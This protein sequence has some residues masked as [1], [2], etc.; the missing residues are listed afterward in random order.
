MTGMAERFAIFRGV[1]AALLAG[2]FTL[3]AQAQQVGA[4]ATLPKFDV[5]EYAVE[6]NTRLP[7][8]DIERAVTPFLGVGKTLRDVEA[9]RLALERAYHDAGYLTVLVSIPEQDVGSGEVSL[10]VTE[11]QVERLR[12]KGA[13]YHRPSAIREQLPELAEGNVPYFPEMQ[14]QLDALNRSADLKATPVLKAGRTV[15]TVDIQMEV[16]DTL[17]LHG[18]IDFDNR[19]SANTTAQRLSGTLRYDNLWQRGHSASL[20]LQTSPEKTDEVR[21]A[22]T[23]YVMPVGDRGAAL[24]G[25]AVISRSKFAT[26]A[27]S[28][29][30]GL[31][32]DSNIYGLR[33]ALPLP[34]TA[35]LSQSLSVGLDY[36]DVKQTVV[37][38][39]SSELPAPISYAP[40][41]A[42]WNGS[43]LGEGRSTT[44][45][46]T[47]THGLRG[48]IG[49][50]DAE[51]A[52]KR[53]GASASFFA[54]RSGLQ[55]TETVA[56]W[57]LA[58]KLEMQLAS[59]PLVSNEQFAAG[60]AESVRGYLEGERV[61]DAALRWSFEVRTP[62]V[63]FAGKDS[64]LRLNGLAFYEGAR[65]RTLQSVAPQPP[66][67]LLRGAGLGLRLGGSHGVSL[68]VDWARAIDNADQTRAGDNRV[69]ARLLWDF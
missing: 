40:L 29:G 59:G 51:F 36:K 7:D 66:F 6:G 56:R 58:G 10:T 25:Y 11:G 63:G 20:T 46:A 12:V 42:A 27:G 14:R 16:D 8:I 32:G 34:G 2:V 60:G 41:V 26:L 45:D 5:M 62:K 50:R 57:T 47:A 17:P 15:G 53:S 4:E 30:L 23:T 52:A 68:D 35:S 54:L 55:H 33:Y 28:P 64:P 48:L 13:D 1:V 18:S 43:W 49:N 21:T 61:G 31:L 22:A 38:A 39:G 67:Q 3:P 69:H 65:L 24:V 9:A 44:L 37:V 19:Q